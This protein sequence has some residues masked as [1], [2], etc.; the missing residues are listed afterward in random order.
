[1]KNVTIKITGPQGAGK[2]LMLKKITKL[3]I[4]NLC[5]VIDCDTDKHALTLETPSKVAVDRLLK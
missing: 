3:L 4:D 2:G 1:M 5:V